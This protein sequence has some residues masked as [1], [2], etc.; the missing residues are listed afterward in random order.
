MIVA[1]V[2]LNHAG[3]LDLAHDSII[4][5]A[6]AGCDGVKFQ[7]FRTE[8]FIVDRALT[9]TY[10]SQG[11][12]ITEPFYDL[13]KRYEF[14]R[15][16]MAPLKALSDELGVEFLS[17]PS[18]DDG[19]ADLADVGCKFVKNGSDYLTHTPLLRVMAESGMTVIVSTGM[20]EASDIDAAMDA[21]APALPDKVVLLHCTSNYPTRDGDVNLRRMLTLK[22][23]YD[24]PVGYSDHSEGWQAAVQAVSLG[25][26]MIEKHFT[27]SRDLPGP[28]H[29]FSA[30]PEE[31]AELVR[32]VRAAETRMGRADLR[33]A[34][35]EME[36]R[37][38]YRISV[39][40]DRDL[41]AGHELARQDVAFRKPGTGIL[42]RDLDAYLGRRLARPVGHD[43]PVTPAH[44]EH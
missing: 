10:T 17:A 15:Q 42:P 9:Y 36:C 40:A 28:D 1:E 11:N 23:R 24:V 32:Q 31:M 22:E 44:F 2:G 41:A 39:I 7:N 25:A 14:Q 37:E 12:E 8:D 3:E 19:V 18:S 21:L 43:E 27:L 38:E 34:D 33:P 13:C 4:A 30:T 35:G 5:A 26:V 6:E 20:A 16:W 29:W